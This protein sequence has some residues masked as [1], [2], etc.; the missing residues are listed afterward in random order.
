MAGDPTTGDT[1][2][3]IATRWDFPRPGDSATAYHQCYQ[4][5]PSRT[6]HT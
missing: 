3:A 1:V 6:L 4:Q 2:A 5:S